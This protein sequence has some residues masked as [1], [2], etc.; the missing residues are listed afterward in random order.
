[1]QEGLSSPCDATPVKPPPAAASK[2]DRA[3]RSPALMEL[4]PNLL[5]PR[6]VLHTPGSSA[7][8]SIRRRLRSPAMMSSPF[9]SS[10]TGGTPQAKTTASG[11]KAMSMCAPDEPATISCGGLA[12]GI[13]SLFVS[14]APGARQGDEQSR[15]PLPLSPGDECSSGGT[16]EPSPWRVYGTTS[17]SAFIAQ[18]SP[19]SSSAAP[20]FEQ[21]PLG[22]TVIKEE[23]RSDE[24]ASDVDASD[25]ETERL[26]GSFRNYRLDTRP[27]LA[28]EEEQEEEEDE[29]DN[30]EAL[31]EGSQ[32]DVV[33][34]SAE[35]TTGEDSVGAVWDGNDAAVDDKDDDEEE[36][37]EEE[38][39]EQQQQQ[40]KSDHFPTQ[41]GG[42]VELRKPKPPARQGWDVAWSKTSQDWY[43]N[44]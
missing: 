6:A 2:R 39:E 17:A 40:A 1:M 15:P 16:G 20:G 38:E 5:M 11:R 32:V 41:H 43:T 26:S 35:L 21:S 10:K 30:D 29:E 7:H 27:S 28:E 25:E 14:P 12:A 8:K 34:S 4:P 23:E 33:G 42:K 22:I 31:V 19:P 13:S 44:V 3:E 9:K 24:E 36:E 18:P 37:E